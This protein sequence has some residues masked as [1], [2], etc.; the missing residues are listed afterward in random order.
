[1]TNPPAVADIPQFALETLEQ[2]RASGVERLLERHYQEVAFY[3]D[4]PLEPD[5]DGYVGVEAA[6][7]LRIFTA[8]IRGELV[9][10]C[11]YYR[12]SLEANQDV[13]FVA[14]EHRNARVGAQLLLFC[15][16]SLRAEGVHVTYQHSKASVDL[17]M[18]PFLKRLGYEL[19]ETVWA[20]RLDRS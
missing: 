12:S 3:K 11:A 9:G 5:W 19:V 16:R 13:L 14:P 2:V 10:Y 6:G 1:M 8:R 17:D 18:G 4:I 7:R 15:E 20:K